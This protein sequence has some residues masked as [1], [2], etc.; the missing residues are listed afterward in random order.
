MPF[1][2]A[3]IENG[4]ITPEKLDLSPSIGS[5]YLYLGDILI[6]FGT[7]SVS[8]VGT[9]AY[10]EKSVN[11][12]FPKNFAEVPVVTVSVGDFGNICGEYIAVNP[13]KTN[14][15]AFIGHTASSPSTSAS[16][17]YIAIGKRA[18]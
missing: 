15:T 11:V 6:C 14:F 9:G 2:T 1:G 10:S 13:T 18:D 4:A 5:N 8:G 16:A 7:F 3:D 12:T 17:R